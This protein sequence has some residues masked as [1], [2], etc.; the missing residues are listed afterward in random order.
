MKMLSKKGFGIQNL[1]DYA[2]LFGIAIITMALVAT[3]LVQIKGT[4][5]TYGISSSGDCLNSTGGTSYD[6]TGRTMAS[7]ITGVGIVATKSLADWVPTFVVIVAAVL[8]LG[9]I[10]LLGYKKMQG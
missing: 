6:G 8:V 10:G 4:Q 3:I 1:G 2:L 9:M 5:C 7:N